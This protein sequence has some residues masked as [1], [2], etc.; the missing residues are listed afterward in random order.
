MD[1]DIK[2]DSK[3]KG[4]PIQLDMLNEEVNQAYNNENPFK[5]S[6]SANKQT[7][8]LQ[9]GYFGENP[10]LLSFG[11]KKELGDEASIAQSARQSAIHQEG[12]VDNPMMSSIF[13]LMQDLNRYIEQ[14]KN[15][16][17]KPENDKKEQT[18]T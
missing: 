10:N 1:G 17:S 14:Y 13:A 16:P 4:I 5:V 7:A 3:R 8:V 2:Q 6:S 12:K 11:S 18:I 15:K 9:S